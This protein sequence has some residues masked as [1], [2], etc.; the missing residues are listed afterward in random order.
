MNIVVS[1]NGDPSYSQDLLRSLGADEVVVRLANLGGNANIALGFEYLAL[2]DYL[3]IL[4]DDD[5]LGEGALSR[6]MSLCAS[7]PDLICVSRS[8]VETTKSMVHSF[9][10]LEALGAFPGSISANCF[11]ASSFQGA[12]EVAFQGVI[13]SYPHTFVLQRVLA[14]RSLEVVIHSS[15][16]FIDYSDSVAALANVTRIEA[17]RSQSFAFFGGG[18]LESMKLA[19][20][21]D[22]HSFSRWWL[23]HWHRA[24]MYRIGHPVQARLIDR[25]AQSRP[26]TAAL[27]A[28]SLFPWWRVKN[29]IRPRGLRT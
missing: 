24:S 15:H 23:S 6:I 19:N 11:R 10:D 14:D 20:Q 2:A 13:T 25:L 5:E 28:I 1:V 4:G 21:F 27:W 17:G 3:W 29:R 8:L 9:S 18:L 22:G 16:G 7:G 12:A 26:H